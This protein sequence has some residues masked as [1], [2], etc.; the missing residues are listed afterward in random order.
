MQG[1]FTRMRCFE[2]LCKYI[3]QDC[4]CIK[5]LIEEK[6]EIC[7]FGQ[8]ISN[9]PLKNQQSCQG[10]KI[11]TATWII[12]REDCGFLMANCFF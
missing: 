11:K 5:H 10:T 9:L 1:Y 7:W 6:K 2:F 8:K 4:T 3:E 12:K